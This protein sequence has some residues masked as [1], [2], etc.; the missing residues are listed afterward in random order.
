MTDSELKVAA[1][2][3]AV[4][5]L[6]G[7]ATAGWAIRAGQ[8][9]FLAQGMFLLMLGLA[10]LALSLLPQGVLR[11][12]LSGALSLGGLG[13]VVAQFWFLRIERRERHEQSSRG[14]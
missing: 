5:A 9:V 13:W 2:L 12:S 4:I 14:R 3:A 7:L 10:L 11:T 6:G 8:R 1:V